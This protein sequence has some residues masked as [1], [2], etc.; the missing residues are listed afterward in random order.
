MRMRMV[1]QTIGKLRHEMKTESIVKVITAPRLWNMNMT[2][3]PA[4]WIKDQRSTPTF[5]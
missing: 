4:G 2:V 5:F 1:L 3:H